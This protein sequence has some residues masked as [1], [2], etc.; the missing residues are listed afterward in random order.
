MPQTSA[1]PQKPQATPAGRFRVV[2]PHGRRSGGRFFAFVFLL[3]LAFSS[4]APL[5][6]QG[7]AQAEGPPPGWEVTLA[8]QPYGP[9]ALVGITKDKQQ[10]LLFAQH[11]PLSL[12]GQLPCSTGERDGDKLRAGD[13]K[14]P[15][16]VYFVGKRIEARLDYEMY[17]D[18][19]FALNFPNP[20]DKIKGKTGSGIWIHGK[21]H[22][23]GPRETQG[24]VALGNR[25]LALLSPRLQ[26]GMPVVIANSLSWT[27]RLQDSRTPTELVSKV[28]TWARL[29]EDGDPKFFEFYD[30]DKFS[31]SG[32]S[33]RNFKEHKLQ[34]F[35]ATN[36]RQ[37]R[38][39]EMRVVAGPDYWVTYFGQYYRTGS[40]TTE[41][42]KRLYWQKD[43]QGVMRIV[44]NEWESANLGMERRYVEESVQ[45]VMTLLESWRAA[46]EK[47]DVQKY[48]TFYDSKAS[49]GDR[50]GL[51][52][53]R[54]HKL[55][56][57]K[58]KRPQK[59]AIDDLQ[60]S[61]HPD[62]LKISFI[63][64]YQADGNFKDKGY[65]TILLQ[66]RGDSWRIVKEEWSA[67]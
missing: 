67:M 61:L 2:E 8:G 54:D 10:L 50:V 60:T 6:A 22:D 62:G 9:P 43:E 11:S 41:G 57:W 59:V 28:S 52:S 47:G 38:V 18:G 1:E 3:A 56:L 40:L 12:I 14:T 26:Y 49:Q 13:L 24:C 46:W 34:Q 42:I 32:E 63:Q 25:D 45:Q 19:A 29:W 39:G 30:P 55:R 4:V 7:P 64:G 35:N 66:P 37:V 65:K 58:E 53:I 21:G 31:R 15:E 23:P 48:L 36:W 27:D 17:G 20:I 51:N 44:G 16:G 5:A 33:F